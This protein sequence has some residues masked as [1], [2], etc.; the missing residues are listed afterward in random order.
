MHANV[1]GVPNRFGDEFHC[2]D[3]D[4]LYDEFGDLCGVSEGNLPD[5]SSRDGVQ[6]GT[7]ANEG[8]DMID[9]TTNR[10][11]TDTN[12][13]CT[14]TSTVNNHS[15]VEIVDD[16]ADLEEGIPIPE[17][18]IHEKRP[19]RQKYRKQFINYMKFAQMDSVCVEEIPLDVNRDQKYTIECEEEEHMINRRM[20]AGSRCTQVVVK[21]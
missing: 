6:L 1:S 8:N 18:Y 9:L 3:G 4:Y 13:V 14:V 2:C 5:D 19:K 21:G 11:K 20:D 10:S 17:N 15:D 7:M 12:N 16:P